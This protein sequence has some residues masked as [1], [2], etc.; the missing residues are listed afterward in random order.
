MQSGCFRTSQGF[1]VGQAGDQQ[2]FQV[3]L[4]VEPAAGDQ[5]LISPEVK[6]AVS[7]KSRPLQR[8][9]RSPALGPDMSMVGQEAGAGVRD[10][11]G[12]Q[13]GS[14]QWSALGGLAGGWGGGP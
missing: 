1:P 5:V 14:Q 6:W 7:D 13:A 3:C 2:W 8:L 10:L 4:E 11:T 12:G 9:A